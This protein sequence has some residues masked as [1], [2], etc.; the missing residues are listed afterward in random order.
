MC[1]LIMVA[2]LVSKQFTAAAVLLLAQQGEL[3]IDDE[4]RK[5]IPEMPNYGTPIGIRQLLHH[6]S[7]LRNWGSISDLT[8]WP[9]RKKFYTNE[10]ALAIIV[11]QKHLNNKPGDEFLYSN[12]NY[13]VLGIIVQRVSGVTLAAF[14]RKYTLNPPE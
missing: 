11:R 10:D 1:R 7:G 3:S 4:V 8:G 5:Y 13:N 12:S 2:N 14:T 6:T 9:R